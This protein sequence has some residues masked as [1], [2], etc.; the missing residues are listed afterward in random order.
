[1]TRAVFPEVFNVLTLLGHGSHK[2]VAEGRY[3]LLLMLPIPEN[4]CMHEWKSCSV[5]RMIGWIRV[6]GTK[7]KAP[8]SNEAIAKTYTSY[9]LRNELGKNFR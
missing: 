1:M 6:F 8:P 3:Q 4:N 9:S 5:T 2:N 7:T